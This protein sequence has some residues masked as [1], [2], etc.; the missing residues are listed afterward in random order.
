[1][2][3]SFLNTGVVLLISNSSTFLAM[4]DGINRETRDFDTEWYQTVGSSIILICV[5]SIGTPHLDSVRKWLMWRRRK[6][7][8]AEEQITQAK[9]QKLLLGKEF[10]LSD[11]YA[12][13]MAA[14]S[15]TLMYGSGMPILYLVCAVHMLVA[16]FID[17]YLFIN[18]NFNKHKYQHIHIHIHFNF[19]IN[20]N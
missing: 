16:F 8:Y 13:R 7:L 9:L 17:K 5:L 19:H 18:L 12:Y 6:Y 3:L 4:V 11:R 14:F 2:L 20:V 1:M 15:V 10:Y